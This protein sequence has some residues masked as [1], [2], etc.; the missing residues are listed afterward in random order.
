MEEAMTNSGK[1]TAREQLDRIE[2][3]LVET[4]L[5][6]SEAELR[7]DM[8]AR[9][10]DPD[11]CLARIGE[12]IT[13]EMEKSTDGQGD[14]GDAAVLEIR[15]TGDL[16]KARWWSWT[17]LRHGYSLKKFGAVTRSSHPRC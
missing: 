8:K 14:K 6:A 12:I 16:G 13:T 1:S 11:K 3:A 10:E 2:D 17:G 5:S 15:Q 9:G 7:E 4:I